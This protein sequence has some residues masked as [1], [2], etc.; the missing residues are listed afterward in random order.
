MSKADLDRALKERVRRVYK[1]EGRERPIE[2][3]HMMVVAAGIEIDRKKLRERLRN[4]FDTMERMRRPI[5]KGRSSGRPRLPRLEPAPPPPPVPCKAS[6][7]CPECGD[8]ATLLMWRLGKTERYRC[9]RCSTI[10]EVK[11]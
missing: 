9:K 10:Y 8:D 5:R 2:E 7:D 4:D 11:A 1:F 3:I 6:A